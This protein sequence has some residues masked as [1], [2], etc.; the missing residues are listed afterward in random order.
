MNSSA[1]PPDGLWLDTKACAAL[2]RLKPNT[3]RHSRSDAP[4]LHAPPYCK[5]PNG[6][7]RYHLL[8][9]VDWANR[10][11]KRLAWRALPFSVATRTA[12]ALG[13]QGLPAPR[14]LRRVA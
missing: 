11:G 1:P 8:W 5:F 10:N 6:A 9:V 4:T 12:A 13:A 14:K 3:L 7:V 2:V